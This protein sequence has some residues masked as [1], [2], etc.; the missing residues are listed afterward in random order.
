MSNQLALNNNFSQAIK[1][2]N[3]ECDN[4]RTNSEIVRKTETQLNNFIK[5]EKAK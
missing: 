2:I 5:Q 4:Y 3:K 1:V